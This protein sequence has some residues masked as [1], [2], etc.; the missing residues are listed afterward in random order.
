MK[1]SRESLGPEYND[2]RGGGPS[3]DP[4]LNK[5]K[6]IRSLDGEAESANVALEFSLGKSLSY[7]NS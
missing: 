2:L 1:T 7:L 6:N 5:Q 4:L 3:L